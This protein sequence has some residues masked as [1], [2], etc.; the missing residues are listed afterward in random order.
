MPEN[1]VELGWGA[2]P[3]K[4]QHPVLSDEQAEHFD[5]DNMAI[6][7]LVVRGMIP[8]STANNARK[9]LVKNIENAIVKALKQ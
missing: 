5:N 1:A 2:R 9:K 3:L 4:E 6:S 7:R 8:P